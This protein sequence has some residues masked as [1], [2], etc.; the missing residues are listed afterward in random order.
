MQSCYFIGLFQHQKYL[1]NPNSIY[2]VR[3]SN[4]KMHVHN[5]IE[6]KQTVYIFNSNTELLL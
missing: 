1:L 5:A 6:F 3:K 2:I 4:E